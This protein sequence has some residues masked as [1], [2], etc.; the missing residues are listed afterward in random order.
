MDYE[1][2]NKLKKKSGNTMR[3]LHLIM[4]DQWSIQYRSYLWN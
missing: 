3:I 1:A 2:K 4:Q